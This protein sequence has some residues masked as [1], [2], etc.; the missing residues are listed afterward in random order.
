[1][2]DADGN[3]NVCSFSVF[4]KEMPSAKPKIVCRT[5]TTVLAEI[6]KC[7]RLINSGL[8]PKSASDNCTAQADLTLLVSFSGATSMSDTALALTKG[9]NGFTFNTGV[10]TVRYILQ[11][12]S[13]N[14]DTCT[15]KVNVSDIQ[16]PVITC[17]ND[18][19]AS[20][21]QKCNVKIPNLQPTAIDNC[22]PNNLVFSY[23]INGATSIP[24]S[25]QLIDSVRFNVGVSTVK[26]FVKDASNNTDSCTFKVTVTENIAPTIVC[27]SDLTVSTSDSTCTAFLKN[28]PLPTIADNC[29]LA[30]N[31]KL[32][33]TTSGATVSSANGNVNGKFFEKGTTTVTY[34][35]TDFSNNETTCSFKITVKDTKAPKITCP[36]NITVNTSDS[37]CYAI[38]SG[39]NPVFSDNCSATLSYNITGQTTAN[40]NG[41]FSNIQLNGGQNK[42]TYKATDL[43]GNASTCFYNI[44]I[45]DAIAPKIIC[46]ANVTANTGAD[47]CIVS[48]SNLDPTTSD[49][50]TILNLNFSSTGATVYTNEIGSASNK[51]FEKGINNLTYKTIDGQG[52]LA[53]CNFTLTV[54]DITQPI[55]SCKNKLEKNL[56]NTGNLTVDASL[57][58]LGSFDNCTPSSEL[59]FSLSKSKFD[60]TNI[61]DNALIFSVKDQSGNVSTCNTVLN[62]KKSV[63]NLGFSISS[64]TV[65][66][67]FWGHGNGK[68]NLS[69]TG[70][71]GT[72]SYL[73]NNGKTTQN[74]TDLAAGDYEVT[75]TDEVS[76][77]I[78]KAIVK[79]NPGAKLTLNSS[80]TIAKTAEIVMIPVRVQHF[81]NVTDLSFSLRMNTLTVAEI[82]GVE[83]FALPNIDSTNYTF[84]KNRVTFKWKNTNGGT[85]LQNGTALFF[86]K[87]KIIG[88]LGEFTPF[89][90]EQIPMPVN[91]KINLLA[92]NTDV[93]L[94]LQNGSIGVSNGNLTADLTSNFLRENGTLVNKVSCVLKGTNKDSTMSNSLG[95]VKFVLPMGT[96]AIIKPLRNDNHKNGLT[97]SD[98]VMMQRH[99]LGIAFLNSPYKKIAADINKNGTI[100]ASDLTELRYL[101]LGTINVFNKNTSW[102]FVPSS[103]VFPTSTANQIPAF[104]DS[105]VY[106]YLLD[107]QLDK[108][109]VAM[110]IGDVNLTS[111]NFTNEKSED[112][113]EKILNFYTENKS[114][115]VNEEVEILIK[116]K[117]KINVE[118]LDLT[119]NFDADKM[120][121]KTISPTSKHTFT[122]KD[123][124][125]NEAKN[126]Q[127]KMVNVYGKGIDWEE[128]DDLIKLVF[129]AKEKIEDLEKVLSFQNSTIFANQEEQNL[130][131]IFT[132]KKLA[133][134]TFEVN[135]ITPNPTKDFAIVPIV[136]SEKGI[137]KTTVFD[138]NGRVVMVQNQEIFREFHEVKI[139]FENLQK[140]IYIVE[141]QLN[142]YI[143]RQKIFVN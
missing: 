74:L 45:K 73:W 96:K 100:T 121:F 6:G 115:E 94:A 44:F 75:V 13:G 108:N 63:N 54:L 67:T 55:I 80:Q 10:T 43:D 30:A 36:N 104:P 56:D 51:V 77:C 138:M 37:T 88:S 107:N 16:K 120:T 12:A 25:T 93:P 116:N 47:N 38:V 68:I 102:R 2:V 140:G 70:G 40:G 109:F 27:P 22:S 29:D 110:K 118:A 84:Q 31:L 4:L 33:F 83:N 92:G 64:T 111:T 60:C 86:I 132:K 5:D 137:L 119:L 130:N 65:D 143:N 66:E 128:N 82:L 21:G 53:T 3:S 9:A 76:K 35:V 90:F 11:D 1:V 134:G 32:S 34:K 62:V 125:E 19:T 106:D 136:T 91:A 39:Q 42:V 103:F 101:L 135:N 26:F 117:S 49:N 127:I 98:L 122:A 17:T 81:V 58:D 15:F 99:I 28:I 7:N 124:N 97:A 95:F 61:G 133:K 72:F 69:V 126:G 57:F 20:A 78:G 41:I 14:A 113:T 8:S 141:N 18:V 59:I 50:C 123:I 142:G 112:R 46:P 85:S 129:T 131:L 139:D 105:L 24:N 79:I 52:N 71:L 23:K 87:A 48:L 114:I 89:V